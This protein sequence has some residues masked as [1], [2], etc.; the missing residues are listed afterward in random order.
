MYTLTMN[1]IK[2]KWS[3]AFQWTCVYLHYKC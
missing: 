2:T 1:K 3:I